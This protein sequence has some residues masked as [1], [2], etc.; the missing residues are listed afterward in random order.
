MSRTLMIKKI[1]RFFLY[2]FVLSLRRIFLFLPLSASL[3]LGAFLGGLAFYIDKSGRK[4]AMENLTIAFPEKTGKEMLL[5]CKNAYKNHGR[6]FAEFMHFPKFKGDFVGNIVKFEGRENLKKAYDVGRGTIIITAHFGNWELLGAAIRSLGYPLSVI[7][8]EFYIPRINEMIVKNR[9][10]MG[11]N[12]I[13]R[14]TERSARE[15][16]KTLKNNQMIG[17]LIDQDTAVAGEFVKFFSK[18]AYT[19]IGPA[20]IAGKT[21]CSVLFAFIVRNSDNTHTAF[22][23]GPID[24]LRTGD[25]K[26]DVRENTQF[27]TK[28]IEDYITKHP[29]HWVWFHKRWKTKKS[30]DYEPVEKVIE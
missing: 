18:E 4:T 15:I 29:E 2:I 27:Y 3:S 13:M 24:Y 10:V 21:C 26:R 30:I 6:N 23:E 12:V 1:S 5:I 8:R 16:L 19:P 25:E 7:A 11:L 20:A 17:I 22:I 28:K 14:A 9:T